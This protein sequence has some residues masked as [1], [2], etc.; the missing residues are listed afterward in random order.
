[1][2]TRRTAILGFGAGIL[3]VASPYLPAPAWAQTASQAMTLVRSTSERL[4]A[5]VNGVGTPG[6]KRRQLQQVV[7]AAVDVEDIAR[8]CLGRFWRTA[9]QDQQRQYVGLFHDLLLTKISDHFGEY[10]GVQVTMGPAHASEGN[11]V[12]ITTVERPDSPPFQVDWVVS[13]GSGR[14]KIVDLLAGGTSLR[15]TQTSDFR[16]YLSRHKYDIQRLIDGM[17]QLVAQ[18]P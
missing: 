11:Q 1:M 18:N 5:V 7:D 3:F 17:Q 8:S 4:V 9:T 2:P 16:A 12:V 15:V 6:E 14:P 10:H 13:T